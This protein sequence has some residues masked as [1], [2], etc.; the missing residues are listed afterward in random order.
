MKMFSTKHMVFTTVQVVPLQAV[1]ASGLKPPCTKPKLPL[2]PQSNML[3]LQGEADQLSASG[4]LSRP[5]DQG[6]I[7]KFSWPSF[8]RFVKAFNELGTYTPI[9]PIASPTC[10]D[11]MQQISSYKLIIK[12]HLTKT[13]FQ[14]PIN[15]ESMTY[16]GTV[17]P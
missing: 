3:L 13:F 14:I 11:V 15:K 2:Y 7:V 5:E 4:I 1:L 12:T 8:L 16:L 17:T 10:N 9:P 6:V